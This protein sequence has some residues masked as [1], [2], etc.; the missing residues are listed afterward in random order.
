MCGKS[1]NITQQTLCGIGSPCHSL[2]III[3]HDFGEREM[4]QRTSGGVWQLL[5][6]SVD[7]GGLAEPRGFFCSTPPLLIHE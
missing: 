7:L 6:D 3:C 1:I 4:H 2:L 5:D